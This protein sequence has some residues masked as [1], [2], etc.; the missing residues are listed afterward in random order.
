MVNASL[1][2]EDNLLTI[3]LYHGTSTLFLDSIIQY[4][5]GGINPVFEWNIL[6]LSKKVYE[7][8]EQYLKETRL[9]K[10]SSF[11][12]KK[13]TEQSNNGTFNFRHGDSYLSPS[14]ETACRYAINKEYGS[15]ILTYTINFLKE[16]LNQD[17]PY[18]KGELFRKFPKI[19]GLI[20]AKPS[21]L[22]IQIKN[23][24]ADSLL[25]EHGDKPKHNFNRL[26]E[27][28][29]EGKNLFDTLSQQINFRLTKPIS[30]DNLKF[31]LINVQK[32]DNYSPEFNLYEIS[33]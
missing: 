18:V 33:E 16:L 14:Q 21:P 30:P 23:I 2:N 12:F 6:E 8:S 29:R 20:E 10:V 11:S 25:T 32:W 3:D 1:I 15:E 7:L 13:M 5:L 19:F 27:Y 31:L 28:M 26:Q 22:L 17:I 9:F 24:N 4:G